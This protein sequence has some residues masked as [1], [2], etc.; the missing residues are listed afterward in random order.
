MSRDLSSRERA[1][2]L[3]TVAVLATS[4]A[5][6]T[7]LQLAWIAHAVAPR[8][9]ALLAVA[10][11]VGHIVW[12]ALGGAALALIALAV[13][14]VPAVLIRWLMEGAR[15]HQETRHA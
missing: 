12:S 5:W 11:A 14:G 1:L 13:L 8:F 7:V 15:P 3:G 9:A 10:R 2:W 6:M 4:L